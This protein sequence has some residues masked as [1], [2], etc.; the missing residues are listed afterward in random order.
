[1]SICRVI[2]LELLLKFG[3]KA[4]RVQNASLGA[5]NARCALAV[6]PALHPAVLCS[7]LV[8]YAQLSSTL[9]CQLVKLWAGLAVCR[10][11]AS[12]LCR[13][14][15]EVADIKAQIDSVNRERKLQQTAAGQELA[16]LETEWQVRQRSTHCNSGTS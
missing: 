4:W 15:N 9:A 6:S 12:T 11:L 13:L 8:C 5:A 7:F 10:D 16:M 14:A 2:N 1:M 3:P